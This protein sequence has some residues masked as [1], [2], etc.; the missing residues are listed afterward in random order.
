MSDLGEY[1]EVPYTGFLEEEGTGTGWTLAA[2][3]GLSLALG[4]KL[5]VFLEIGYAWQRV[6]EVSGPGISISSI[7]EKSWDGT[8]NM[9]YIS[10]ARSWGNFYQEFASNYWPEDQLAKLARP[11][12]LDMS[13]AQVRIGFCFRL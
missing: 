5:G 2:G 9:K 13:G 10:L 7:E 6:N 11:F 4:P 8:W 12:R 1:Y 3:A